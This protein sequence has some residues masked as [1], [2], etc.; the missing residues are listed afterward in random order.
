VKNNNWLDKLKAY[1]ER[2]N[3]QG[4]DP[5]DALNCPIFGALSFNKKALRMAFIQFMKKLPINIRPFLG[6]RKDYNPKGIGLFLW[7]YA[8]LYKLTANTEL[9]KKIDFFL[10]LLETLKSKSY[11]GNCWGYNFDW[12][13]RAFFLPKFTPTIV[14]SSFVGHALI[15]TYQFTAKERALEMALPI[16]AF[17]LRD[18]NRK[19][20][21]RGICFS[22][23]PLD[24]SSVHNANLLGASLLIRLYKF[25][26]DEEL[27]DAALASLA[28]SMSYQREDGSWYYAET[29]YQRW[30]DSFHT[31][32]NLQSILYFL[33]E[34]YGLEYKDT[35]RMG[36]RFYAE[37]FFFDDGAPK[38]YHDKTYPLDIHSGAQAVV[39]FSRIGG[40][41]SLKQ[42]IL[43]WMLKTMQDQEGFFYYQKN[44]FF[45][46]KIPYMR[47]AQA[48][49]LHALTSFML[50]NEK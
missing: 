40:Y 47:W 26:H 31:G 9:L 50:S 38:Y 44:R 25:L 8:K 41:A 14:N 20:D 43:Q 19:E 37:N 11:S 36:V 49:A 17:I 10:D 30:I 34:G 6:I 5:Y 15:D 2:E 45:I 18:L 23:S 21:A 33:E 12:Q 42:E 13:S 22:Y 29:D 4:F 7:S 46:N 3:F 39:L 48:W 35:F 27:K 1:V 32:F 16:S 28:Y 24:E